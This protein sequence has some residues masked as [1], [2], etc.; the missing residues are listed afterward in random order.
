MKC[1]FGIK[2][3]EEHRFRSAGEFFRTAWD[4][5]KHLFSGIVPVFVSPG[6]MDPAFREKV[7]LTVTWANRCRACMAVHSRWG[8]SAGVK[9]EE[10]SDL[11]ILDPAK[12]EHR[13]WVALMYARDYILFDGRIPDE[14]IT[15]EYKKLYS[16]KERADI[17]AMIKMMDFSNR[18]NNT[19]DRRRVESRISGEPSRK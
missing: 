8:K 6:R 13:E 2:P 18:F 3:R 15:R 14:E 4:L 9:E 17:L 12:F 10:I 11:E 5:R 7:C 1:N 16:E 19:W